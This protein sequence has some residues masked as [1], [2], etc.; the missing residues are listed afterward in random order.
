M[1]RFALLEKEDGHEL[2]IDNPFFSIELTPMPRISDHP[3]KRGE[4]IE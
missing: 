1:G 4:P 2:K 3:S